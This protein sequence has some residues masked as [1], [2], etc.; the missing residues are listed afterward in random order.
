MIGTTNIKE[1]NIQEYYQSTELKSLRE[2][3]LNESPDIVEC[4][5]C[6]QEE[7]MSGH[8]MRTDGLKDHKF[9]NKKYYKQQLE[10]GGYLDKIFPQ[11]IECIL[12][13]YVI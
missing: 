3:L 11:R 12:E 6:Y 7:M 1:K 10:Y 9:L 13:I 4:K 2:K 8:S 5:K